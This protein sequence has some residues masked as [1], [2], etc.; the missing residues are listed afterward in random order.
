M[1]SQNGDCKE[2]SYFNPIEPTHKPVKYDPKAFASY[3]LMGKNEVLRR[4]LNSSNRATS[5][6]IGAY[7]YA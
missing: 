6:R 2:D 3:S 4:N 1:H 5:S 7:S